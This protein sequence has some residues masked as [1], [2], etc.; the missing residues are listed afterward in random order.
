MK[1]WLSK[2]VIFVTALLLID[3]I[4][5]FSSYSP[6][7]A[8]VIVRDGDSCRVRG[9]VTG[10]VKSQF[11]CSWAP[12]TTKSRS[13]IGRRLVWK[14][15]VMAT[16]TT[17]TTTLVVTTTSTIPGPP[18]CSKGGICRV[19]DIGAGGGVVFFVP[20]SPRWW[21][22]YLEAAPYRW[23]NSYGDNRHPAGCLGMS[24]PG[25]RNVDIGYGKANT[26]SIVESCKEP[27]IAARVADDLVI[28][29]KS[30]WFLPSRDEMNAMYQQRIIIGGIRV[31]EENQAYSSST[32]LNENTFVGQLFTDDTP[33]NNKAGQT[34][35]PSRTT[36]YSYYVRPIRYGE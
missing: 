16:T 28:N 31:A 27:D 29:G 23:N 36:R 13:V 19:G 34:F 15:K 30:D 11:V 3:T 33:L 35:N 14:Q 17:T 10:T 4:G 5:S 21:G 25:A 32:F 12:T 24:I 18:P 1:N 26:T 9:Q 2:I 22:R 7:V 8:A 20:E 6:A